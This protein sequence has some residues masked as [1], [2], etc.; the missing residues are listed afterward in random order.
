MLRSLEAPVIV[1]RNQN[2]VIRIERP[3]FLITAVG[4]TM[5]DGKVG[6]YI[7]VTNMDS[8]RII[9]AKITEEGTVEPVL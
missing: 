6:E 3:G 5:Q 9:I 7:K 4:K 8:Q 1:K 2:V